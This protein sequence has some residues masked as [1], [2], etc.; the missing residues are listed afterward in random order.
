M[1][2]LNLLESIGLI[3]IGVVLLIIIEVVASKKH[4]RISGKFGCLPYILIIFG[5]YFLVS[6]IWSGVTTFFTNST[7]TATKQ[8]T[9]P[10]ITDGNKSSATPLSL[11]CYRWNNIPMKL[12]GHQICAYGQ[13]F[14]IATSESQATVLTFSSRQ[15]QFYIVDA[16]YTYPDLTVGDCVSSTALLQLDDTNIP[17]MAVD[18]LFN[19]KS[20]MK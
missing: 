14:S 3:A 8:S 20:W 9:T 12:V 11:D 4:L 15:D 7:P 19:C 1:E 13:V 18:Q 2:K 17:Y 10:V 16:E 5:I 6:N